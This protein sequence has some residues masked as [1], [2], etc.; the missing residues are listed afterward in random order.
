LLVLFCS[1]GNPY[2]PFFA[3]KRCQSSCVNL[4]LRL[5]LSLA[6]LL[7]LSIWSQ[8]TSAKKQ[9]KTARK[10][11]R[12]QKM[13]SASDLGPGFVFERDPNALASILNDEGIL[14]VPLNKGAVQAKPF[15]TGLTPAAKKTLGAKMRS[16][17][18]EYDFFEGRNGKV[19]YRPK[20]AK[21]G[22]AG[23]FV[24]R[25]HTFDHLKGFL[26]LNV[27]ISARKTLARNRTA[28]SAAP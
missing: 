16:Q 4:S 13:T 10:R 15:K 5:L 23:R 19:F 27:R 6:L 22:G 25:C 24:S 21:K 8:R 11:K 2:N 12:N 18:A 1:F 14:G 28:D 3:P 17:Q 7:S 9:T 20:S 26:P